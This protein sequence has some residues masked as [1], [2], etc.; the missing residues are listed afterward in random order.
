MNSLWFL[1]RKTSEGSSTRDQLFK[2]A[3]SLVFNTNNKVQQNY[4]NSM[5][6]LD[7]ITCECY[8]IAIKSWFLKICHTS[9]L[10]IYRTICK[11]RKMP[12]AYCVISLRF[13]PSCNPVKLLLEK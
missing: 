10:S 3:L 13:I 9:L 4:E 6:Y 5:Y 8:F 11:V 2:H 7:D 1:H 12:R